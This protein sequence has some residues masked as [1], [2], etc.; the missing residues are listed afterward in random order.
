MDWPT[1]SDGKS[2]LYRKRCNH[3][4]VD[5]EAPYL[6]WWLA[7]EG[8]AG[9]KMVFVCLQCGARFTLNT[10]VL[11]M[12]NE[13]LIN[14]D[15][16]G[17]FTRR[18]AAEIVVA[19]GWEPWYDQS[20]AQLARP[21]WKEETRKTGKGRVHRGNSAQKMFTLSVRH[22]AGIWQRV[23]A[24]PGQWYEVTAWLYVWCSKLDNPDTSTGKY[25][26]R[27]GA[28]PWGHWPTHYAT[29]YGQEALE[30]YNRYVPV[31]HLFQAWHDEVSIVVQG[32]AEYAVKHNDLYIDLV[33]LRP[34]TVYI[35]EEPPE[36]EP[37]TPD[38]GE[39][40]VIDY[41]RIATET[42]EQ[43]MA[44]QQ[45]KQVDLTTA[46]LLHLQGET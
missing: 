8:I 20:T 26:A 5:P 33:E 18:H 19:N 7:A 40:V 42:A 34:V 13:T 17:G 14:G 46:V 4:P 24:M 21:E 29:M 37:P 32:M 6:G 35:D 16:E 22:N 38:P 23:R 28:N 31:R 3:C 9:G 30:P 41:A 45:A 36:P 27:I 43:V 25:R 44:L 12:V 10:E 2:W 39:P 15:F 1:L 11:T